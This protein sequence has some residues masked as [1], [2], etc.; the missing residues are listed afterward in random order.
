LFGI[1][2]TC[3]PS[4]VPLTIDPFAV[5]LAARGHAIVA[6]DYPGVGVDEGITSFLVGSAEAA[7]TLDGVRALRAL[8]DP[9]FDA[10]RLGSDMFVVGHSQGGHAALFTHQL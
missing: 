7:A 6:P 8:R 5:P 10:R 2:P 4:H 1:G 9:R 3:G